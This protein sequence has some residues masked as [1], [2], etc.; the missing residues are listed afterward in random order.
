MCI[1]INYIFSVCVGKYYD[2]GDAGIAWFYL[3]VILTKQQEVALYAFKPESSSEI[4]S[5][6]YMERKNR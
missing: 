3:L 6:K 5:W 2:P 1:E 4:K